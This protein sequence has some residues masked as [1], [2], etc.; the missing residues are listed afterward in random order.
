MTPSDPEIAVGLLLTYM[1]P[2]GGVLTPEQRDVA[3]AAANRPGFD[4]ARNVGTMPNRASRPWISPVVWQVAPPLP[5]SI[6][7]PAQHRRRATD[8]RDAGRPDLPQ[9]HDNC[10]L[11]VSVCRLPDQAA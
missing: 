10:A 9:H 7:T 3:A 6:L 5:G 4:R 2:C 11:I 8:L 1:G